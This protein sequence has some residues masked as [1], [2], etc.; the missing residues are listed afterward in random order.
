MTKA[1]EVYKRVEELIAGGM[2][3]PEAFKAAAE[4]YGQ[5]VNSMRGAYY[6]HA[7]GAGGSRSRPRRRE[8][9]AEDAVND[10]RAALQRAIDN[11]D[12]EVE[13]AKERADEAKAEYDSLKASAAERKSEIAK[14]LEALR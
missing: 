12:R 2:T 13:A 6:A 8:T 1:E 3:K 9:T 14:R 4:H 5:P 7:R 10:A 11:V